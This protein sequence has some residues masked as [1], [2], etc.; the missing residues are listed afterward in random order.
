MDKGF[1][2]GQM[3]FRQ[4]NCVEQALFKLFHNL[5]IQLSRLLFKRA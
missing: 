2:V 3:F 4:T 5:G 1:D